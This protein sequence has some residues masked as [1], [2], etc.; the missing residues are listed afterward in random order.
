VRR[1]TLSVQGDADAEVVVGAPPRALADRLTDP[2]APAA[3]FPVRVE[4]N[5]RRPRRWRAGSRFTVIAAIRGEQVRMA[6]TVRRADADGVAFVADGPVALHCDLRF[7]RDGRSVTRVRAHVDV[8]GRGIAGDAV[9]GATAAL[10]RGGAL[11]HAL[12]VVKDDVE[13]SRR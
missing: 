7:E 12:Q 10:L 8:T 2:D 9:A 4:A 11:D 3:W 6:V 13:R 5:G 1:P